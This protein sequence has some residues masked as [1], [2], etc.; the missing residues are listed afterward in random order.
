[1]PQL[2]V[3]LANRQWTRDITGAPT[4]AVL[5]EYIQLWEMIDG[6]QLRHDVSDR[7]VWKW[8]ATGEY[9]SSSAY[10]AFFFGTTTLLGAN[11]LWRCSAPPK[12]KF[13]FWLTSHGQIWTAERRMRHGLQPAADC[14]LC[15]QDDETSDHL[16]ASCVFTREVWHRLLGLVG[17]QH[18]SP[19]SGSRIVDWWLQTRGMVPEHHRRGFDSLVLL[20]SWEV[21]K[22]RNRRTFDGH[23]KTPTQLLGVIRDDGDSWIAAGF[24]GLAQLFAAVT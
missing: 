3:S 5:V 21:W 22:E 9:T 15:G 7:L 17:F 18:L 10:R 20:V 12:V 24:R 14:A 8:A 4:A 16:L 6:V 11:E 19:A 13:F 2:A 1:L 23:S